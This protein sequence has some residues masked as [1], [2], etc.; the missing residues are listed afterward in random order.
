MS[1][2]VPKLEAKQFSLSESKVPVSRVVLPS[3]EYEVILQTA[4]VRFFTDGTPFKVEN[5]R[6][7]LGKTPEMAIGAAVLHLIAGVRAK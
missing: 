7:N 3:A 2:D 6:L 5:N 4:G 1:Q